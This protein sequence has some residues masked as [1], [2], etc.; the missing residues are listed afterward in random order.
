MKKTL[1]LFLSA[2]AGFNLSAQINMDDSTAQVV[3][4]WSIDDTQSFDVSYEKY[5]IQNGDTSARDIMK[6]VVDITIKDSTANSYTIEWFYR[7]YSSESSNPIVQKLTK[8]SENL[9]VLIKT[10]EYGTI[11]EVI[12]WEEV[13][14][15]VQKS[16]QTLKEELKD[17]PTGEQIV[18]QMMATYTTKE[19]IESNAIKDAQQFY[20]FHGGAYTLHE[21][22]AAKMQFMNNYGGAPFETDVTLSLDE[23]DEE[24][25]YGIIRMVQE[26]NSVQLTDATYEYLKKMGT[27]GN[28]LPPRNEFPAL[29]NNIWTTTRFHAGS[30][31]TTYT[32]ETK[33]VEAEGIS[34]I[35]ERVIQIQ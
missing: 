24:S 18:A 4:Y 34:N 9:S 5:R 2:I 13:R 31:W 22:I 6:Y 15:Y 21:E 7:D 30:G 20:T 28:Q 10:N 12:N 14:D 3:G 19:A 35:E 25:S 17:M 26:V 1:L 8:L 16:T 23:I 33:V 27:L 11:L 32:V 29:T